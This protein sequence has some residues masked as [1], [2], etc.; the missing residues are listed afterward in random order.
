MDEEAVTHLAANLERLD[1]IN[2]LEVARSVVVLV[3]AAAQASAKTN[4]DGGSRRV[5][6]EIEADLQ[7]EQVSIETQLL[8]RDGSE[9]MN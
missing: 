8:S 3:E 1:W 7:F 5:R 9:P 4:F 2:P 6:I